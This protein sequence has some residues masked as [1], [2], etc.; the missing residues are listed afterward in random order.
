MFES[1]RPHL[2]GKDGDPFFHCNPLQIWTDDDIWAYISRYNIPYSALYKMGY[3]DSEGVEHRHMR[4][5]CMGCATAI[6][7]KDNQLSLLR[8]T[9]PGRWEALMRYGM[10]TELKKLYHTKSKGM[11]TIIDVFADASELLEYRPCALDDIGDRL[12]ADGIDDEYDPEIA[13]KDMAL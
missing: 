4:N 11:P 12:D 2:G 8:R 10:A 3:T 9:H 1:H 5:G 6:L 13:P 7:R